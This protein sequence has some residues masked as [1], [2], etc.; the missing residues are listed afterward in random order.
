M[1]HYILDGEEDAGSKAVAL[2][3][4]SLPGQC[5][6][7]SRSGGQAVKAEGAEFGT[8]SGAG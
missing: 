6:G 7:N 2:P 8:T 1:P 5:K 3:G 4:S